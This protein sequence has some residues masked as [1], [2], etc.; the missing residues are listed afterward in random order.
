[1]KNIKILYQKVRLFLSIVFRDAVSLPNEKLSI[2]EKINRLMSIKTAW[3]VAGIVWD[4]NEVKYNDYEE[5]Q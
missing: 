3:G 5:V 2:I 4:D 1:M